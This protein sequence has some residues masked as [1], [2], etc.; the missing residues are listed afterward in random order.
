VHV[1]IAD[2]SRTIVT[3]KRQVKA[4]IGK[5][6]VDYAQIVEHF[7]ASGLQTLTPRSGEVIRCLVDDP[8]KHF[9]SG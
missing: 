4:T 5:D 3:A 8:E 2:H 7:Q 6:F 9:P 1:V